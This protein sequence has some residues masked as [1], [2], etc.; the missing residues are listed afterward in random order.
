ML[1]PRVSYEFYKVPLRIAAIR[2]RFYFCI[3][4]CVFTYEFALLA[5]ADAAIAAHIAACCAAINASAE[6]DTAA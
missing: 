1:C 5:A 2:L 4:P 3:K 6:A